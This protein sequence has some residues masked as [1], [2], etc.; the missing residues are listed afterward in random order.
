MAEPSSVVYSTETPI[1]WI[2]TVESYKWSVSAE[3]PTTTTYRIE[4]PCPRC[5]DPMSHETTIVIALGFTWGGSGNELPQTL[6]VACNCATPHS[7]EPAGQ[8]C[9][10]HGP[11]RFAD[12]IV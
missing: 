8:G 5:K 1:E 7:P 4:G 6:E 2:H 3:T 12:N 10:Q 11:I 9:G